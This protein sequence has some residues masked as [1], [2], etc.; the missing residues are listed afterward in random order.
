MNQYLTSL[1]G[2]AIMQAHREKREGR[3]LVRDVDHTQT[4][5]NHPVLQEMVV[6]R[7]ATELPHFQR[8]MADGGIVA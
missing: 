4:F 5:F 6:W 8:T 1:R 7:G 3:I 2:Y